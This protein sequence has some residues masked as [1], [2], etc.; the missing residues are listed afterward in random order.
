MNNAIKRLFPV[1]DHEGDDCYLDNK[2][3]CSYHDHDHEYDHDL[4][5]D[6]L[7]GLQHGG[8]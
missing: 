4:A 3:D 1:Y 2:L 5:G 8:H 7:P 6:V